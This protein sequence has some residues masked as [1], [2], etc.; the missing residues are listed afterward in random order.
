MVVMAYEQGAGERL[1]ILNSISLHNGLT[2]TTLLNYI[3]AD[4]SD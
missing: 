3:I 2:Q 1:E 4:I